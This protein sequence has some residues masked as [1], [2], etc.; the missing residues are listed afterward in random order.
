M[1]DL[2]AI[3]LNYLA[4]GILGFSISENSISDA[5]NLLTAS[6]VPLSVLIGFLFIVMFFVIGLSSRASGLSITS[7]ASKMS[8]VIPVLFSILY[9]NEAMSFLK[10]FGIIIAIIGLVMAVFKKTKGELSAKR[11]L[12]PL[13]LFAGMGLVDSLVKYSQ[14]AYVTDALSSVFTALLFS[15]SFLCGVVVLLFRPKMWRWF[16]NWKLLIVGISLGIVNYGSIYFMIRA[17]NSNI[18]DSSVIFGINNIGIVSL[19]ALIGLVGFRERL[20]RLNW[21]GLFVCLAA[22]VLLSVMRTG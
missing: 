16:G 7:L 9:Y 20:S 3:V 18:F 17:L 15:I 21:V 10:A 8:V 6:W 4:A 5:G 2:N 11:M 12:I 19:S 1:P 14:D 22:I 13:V